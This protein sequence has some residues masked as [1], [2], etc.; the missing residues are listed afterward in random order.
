MRKRGINSDEKIS[1]E[2]RETKFES[3]SQDVT[4]SRHTSRWIY[5]LNSSLYKYIVVL[6]LVYQVPGTY[7]I[8]HI[9]HEHWTKIEHTTNTQQHT[10]ETLSILSPQS[11]ASFMQPT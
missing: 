3:S 5:S 9:E 8:E 4:S 2:V 10:T 11:K 1:N 7:N 6:L